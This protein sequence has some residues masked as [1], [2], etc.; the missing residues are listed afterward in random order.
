MTRDLIKESDNHGEIE[1][2][3]AVLKAMMTSGCGMPKKKAEALG[4]PYPLKSG[5]RRNII[6]KTVS[7]RLVKSLLS[8]L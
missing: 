8:D 4:I 3:E 1:V 2:T 5:W 7:M 6:G